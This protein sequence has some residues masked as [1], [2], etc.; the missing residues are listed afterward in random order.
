MEGTVRSKKY[1]GFYSADLD[2]FPYKH[3]VIQRGKWFPWSY[4]K[5]KIKNY[6]VENNKIPMMNLF[7]SSIWLMNKFLIKIKNLFFVK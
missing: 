5:L 1:K 6:P 2:L 7:E 4:Y 3:H